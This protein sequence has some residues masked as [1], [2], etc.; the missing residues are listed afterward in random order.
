MTPL[1]PTVVS[2]IATCA[3]GV[4]LP[5]T[6]ADTGLT[7]RQLALCGG[8]YIRILMS[9]GFAY[10]LKEGVVQAHILLENILTRVNVMAVLTNRVTLFWSGKL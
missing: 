6:G 7:L 5:P 8:V 3:G 4:F 10:Y 2:P 1:A 9:L